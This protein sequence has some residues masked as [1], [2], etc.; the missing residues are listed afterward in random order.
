MKHTL[1]SVLAVSLLLSGAAF[2]ND[3]PEVRTVEAQPLLAQALRLDDALTFLGSG[4]SAE[5]SRR[6]QALRLYMQAPN[7]CQ[8]ASLAP[9]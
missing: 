4:L 8:C 2:S 3:L 6:L 1:F 7:E 5:D 9:A